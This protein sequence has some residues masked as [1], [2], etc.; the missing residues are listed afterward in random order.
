MPKLFIILPGQLHIDFAAFQQLRKQLVKIHRHSISM[1]ALEESPFDKSLAGN[2]EAMQ[3]EAKLYEDLKDLKKLTDKFGKNLGPLQDLFIQKCRRP[4]YFNEHLNAHLSCSQTTAEPLLSEIYSGATER[5]NLY[6]TIQD[7]HI[8][9]AG[10][11]APEAVLNQLVERITRISLQDAAR[12]QDLLAAAEQSRMVIM[13]KK[14]GQHC[15]QLKMTG[16]FIFVINLGMVHAQRLA[17]YLDQV[18]RNE[19]GFNMDDVEIIPLHL[20]SRHP[21]VNDLYKNTEKNFPAQLSL[22]GKSDSA[23]ALEY[24]RKNPVRE[25]FIKE[26]LQ[27]GEYSCPEFDSLIDAGI[28]HFPRYQIKLPNTP[29]LLFDINRQFVVEDVTQEVQQ[30]FT[31]S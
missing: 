27:A 25:F 15:S 5:F 21:D 29:I 22:H 9:N 30:R 20:F 23:E 4:D 11:D 24:Y 12:G 14:F 18:L 3:E 26:G 1:L 6:K 28:A 19:L 13:S 17:F 10:I 16:G 31:L 2:M 7:L 8:F